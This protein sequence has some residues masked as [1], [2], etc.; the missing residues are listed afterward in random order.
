MLKGENLTYIRHEKI[1]GIAKSGQPY[2][3]ARLTLSDG[4]ESFKMDVNPE[5]DNHLSTF[6]RGDKVDITVVI[7]ES[8]NKTTF[9]VS[10][11]ELTKLNQKAV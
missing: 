8:F 4:L 2:C 9:N 6:R 5:L 7:G 11:V 10:A 1:E 3:F